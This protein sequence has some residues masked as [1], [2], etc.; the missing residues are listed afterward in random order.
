MFRSLI[1]VVALSLAAPAEAKDRAA[2]PG[3]VSVSGKISNASAS[4]Q[5]SKGKSGSAQRSRGGDRDGGAAPSS[6]GAPRGGSDRGPS[7]GGSGGGGSSDGGSSDG[8]SRSEASRGGDDASRG[9]S[10]A[11][12]NDGARGETQR[13]DGAR[14]ASA[15]TE[16]GHMARPDTSGAQRAAAG[17]RQV[18]TS[19]QGAGGRA[20]ESRHAPAN[21][22]GVSRVASPHG[23]VT[24][25]AATRH[26]AQVARTHRHAAAV[27]HASAGRHAYAAHAEASRWRHNYVRHHYGHAR[28]HRPVTWFRPWYPGRPHYWYHGVFVYGPAPV[29][30]RTEGGGAPAPERKVNHEGQFALGVRGATYISGY[31]NGANYGDFGLGIAARYRPVEALGLELQWNYHDDTWAEGTERIQQPLSASVQL[32][33]APWTMVNP[34]ALAGLTLTNRNIQDDTGNRAEVTS[35]ASFWGPHA[36]L[37]L[38]LGLSD[39]TSLNVDGRWIGY[40]NRPEGDAAYPGAFQGNLGVNFYF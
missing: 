7:G 27:H 32:F 11:Q 1:A 31:T 28:W 37:G 9:G 2:V 35:E 16:D 25:A 34:Y 14:P 26:A 39:K 36:G 23:T 21:Y 8:A 22:R 19:R 5:R 6:S 15:R 29:Y 20:T 13:A 38:E 33:A 40:L 3:A 30:A 24:R 4:G 12:R 17:P 18:D 10:E